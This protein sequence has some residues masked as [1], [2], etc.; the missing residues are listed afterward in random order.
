MSGDMKPSAN[1]RKGSALLVVLLMLGIIAVLAATV[2]R[3]VSGAAL[4]LKAARAAVE[5]ESDLRAGIDLGVAAILKLGDDMRSG[6]AAA[7]LKGRR[8]SVRITNERARID[9]NKA[10][11]DVLAGLLKA[12]GIDDTEAASLAA[13]VVE[14]RGGAAAQ[15]QAAPR[16]DD[17]HVGVLG[18]SAIVS[19]PPGLQANALT[20]RTPTLRFFIHPLQLALVPGFS[21][22][23]VKRI[24]SSLTV[25]NG[26]DKINPF[27]ATPNVLTALPEASSGSVEAFMDARDGNVSR[28][29][30]I[31]LLGVDKKLLSED[32]ASGWRLEITIAPRA[33]RVRHG[34]AIIAGV[35]RETDEP[36]HVLYVLDDS[37]RDARAGH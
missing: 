11:A 9:L 8:I 37:D 34:E 16:P 28:D 21:R 15:E 2:A 25:A 30:A 35:D 27:I 14:W 6:E 10:K 33:G 24:F 32:K 18:Q 26:S 29:T 3:S 22:M 4:E 1:N 17:S 31:Q 5:T 23:L 13:N 20:K 36:Y 12:E 7:D 19:A